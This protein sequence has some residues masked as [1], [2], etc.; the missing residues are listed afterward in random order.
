MTQ[1]KTDRLGRATFHYVAPDRTV[2]P[3]ARELRWFKHIERHGP[4]SS[5]YLFE[6]TRDTHRCMD[7]ALRQLQKLRAGGYL[8][9]PPQQRATER[10]EFN[11]YIYD[12]SQKAH[13]HLADLGIAEPTVR[14]TGHWWHAY[15]TA[16]VTSSIEICATRV[17]IRYIP[18]HEILARNNASIAIP[19]GKSIL[20]P[21]QL[22]ALDY[23]GRYRAFALEVD[24]GTEPKTSPAN[25]KSWARSLAQYDEVLEQRIHKSHY[26]LK[27][28]LLVLWVFTSSVKRDRFL[29]LIRERPG[30]SDQFV[31][32]QALGCAGTPR[33]LSRI[34]YR[35]FESP[36]HRAE[37]P[38]VSIG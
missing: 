32:A 15:L 35:L 18:A 1:P 38:L 12:L 37:G 21:D 8:T 30:T 9:L 31:L 10:A 5:Q 6:L 27:A 34:A 29:S 2:R 13:D 4:Q 7:T 19:H 20:I 14:P 3:T 16:C 17:G 33:I 25:R 24:R 26:G 22:F 23:G 36:W 28:N 11:P